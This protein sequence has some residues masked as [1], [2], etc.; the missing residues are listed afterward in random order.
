MTKLNN[1]SVVIL[2]AVRTA[3]GSF[4]G[5]LKNFTPAELGTLCAKE[6]LARAKLS[7]N[8]VGST[9]VGKVIHNGPK[10]AYL[11]RVIGLDAGLPISSHAVTLNRLCGSGL[12]AIIQAAQQI[13]LGDVDAALAGGAESMS[14]SAY[15][16]ESN[17]WGQKIGNSIMQDELTSTLQ[18]PWDNNPMGIT[19]ENI[20][21]KY[22]ISR[23]QQD[24][25]AAKSHQ[26]AAKAIA[27]GHFK[28]QILPIEIK[29]KSGSHIFDTDEHVRADTTTEKLATLKPYFKKDGT[30][31]AAN[32][33]GINDGAAMLVLMSEQKANEQG[34]KPLG[35]LIGY[36]R[37]GVD[38]S[39]MGT[40]P[41][42]AVKHVFEK[43]GLTIDDMDVIESNEAFAVQA[44]C[45][46]NELN[47]PAHKVNPNGG[48]IALGHPVGATGAILST[49]CLYEL[50]RING[51]YGLVTMCIGGGQG[52]AAIF[53]AL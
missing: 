22:T 27:A 41:I 6:A 32:S 11:S 43:T 17:R 45:V 50:K 18:D 2:S 20:A 15:T 29:S 10:D 9:V 13:Q 31:T 19:A 52:I 53:E 25:Y 28:Q 49:K 5:S 24:A 8:Q 51:K 7:P 42:P 34:L 30:V 48:A 38:P 14:S 23:E 3:I 1:N 21:D 26:K 35:R 36:A 44:L 12:E 37:A 4:G 40:G 46:A 16:L 33:S 47:F 39:L